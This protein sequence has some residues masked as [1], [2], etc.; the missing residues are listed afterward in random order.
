MWASLRRCW[1]PNSGAQER[2]EALGYICFSS[3]IL[4]CE[5]SLFLPDPRA[6]PYGSGSQGIGHPC[7]L[8]VLRE[9]SL[10]PCIIPQPGVA[11]KV[12]LGEECCMSEPDPPSGALRSALELGTEFQK[13]VWSLVEPPSMFGLHQILQAVEQIVNTFWILLHI[14]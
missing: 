14:L 6:P 10:A 13:H 1:E 3:H 12:C 4:A 2:Q 5:V 11:Q 9:N 8:T 7:G